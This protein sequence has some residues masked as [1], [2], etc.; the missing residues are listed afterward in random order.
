LSAVRLSPNNIFVSAI[1]PVPATKERPLSTKILIFNLE[2][3]IIH[4]IGEEYLD[5]AIIEYEWDYT[6][7]HIAFITG[8]YYEYEN[9]LSAYNFKPIGAYIFDTEEKTT[10]KIADESYWVRWSEYDNMLYFSGDRKY[11]TKSGKY[12]QTNDVAVIISPDGKYSARLLLY[13]ESDPALE[14]FLRKGNERIASFY[15][16]RSNEL[17]VRDIF[18]NRDSKHLL[19]G[20]HSIS[21]IFNVKEKRV[22]R[23]LD[24]YVIGW[25]SGISKVVS[26]DKKNGVLTLEDFLTGKQLYK[27]KFEEGPWKRP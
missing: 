16:N 3:Q 23:K 12:F 22:V 15:S 20:P 26:Y 7:R 21:F 8:K 25:N 14:V 4:T 9:K 2:G 24:H 19:V 11:D 27:F 10:I 5:Q 18:W 6:G 1:E 13:G 17:M